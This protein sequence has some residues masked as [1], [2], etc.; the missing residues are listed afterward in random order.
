MKKVKRKNL[1]FLHRLIC[2]SLCV[3]FTIQKAFV[4]LIAKKRGEK[5]IVFYADM[6]L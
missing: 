5:K 3:V 2:H 6:K 1:L 4:L